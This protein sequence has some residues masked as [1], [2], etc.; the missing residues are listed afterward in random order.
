L[1]LRDTLVLNANRLR[2]GVEHPV[3][4]LPVAERSPADDTLRSACAAKG[5]VTFDRGEGMWE[6]NGLVYFTVTSGGRKGLGQV[7]CLDTRSS[8]NTL[9]LLAECSDPK[10]AQKVDCVLAQVANIFFSIFSV[11]A[12]RLSFLDLLAP[13]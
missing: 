13:F 11:R 4:W 2:V 10:V 3:I 12:T 7:F 6:H 9:T 5:A 8:I 1:G